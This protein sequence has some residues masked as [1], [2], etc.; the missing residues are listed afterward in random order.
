M[1]FY[2]RLKRTPEDSTP[3]LLPAVITQYPVLSSDE[4]FPQRS[5]PPFILGAMF[6]TTFPPPI[7]YS[8]NRESRR[9]KIYER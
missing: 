7:I 6:Y 4:K 1:W 5:S 9:K 8:I 2:V 3:T